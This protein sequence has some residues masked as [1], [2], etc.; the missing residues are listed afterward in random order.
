MP[1]LIL[2]V[3]VLL[4]LGAGGGIGLTQTNAQS[5]SGRVLVSG[6]ET[7]KSEA[8]V[9]STKGVNKTTAAKPT[10]SVTTQLIIDT[11]LPKVT[12]IA[13]QN[14]SSKSA[15]TR[16]EVNRYGQKGERVF[17]VYGYDER[18]VRNVI[19]KYKSFADI[20]ILTSDKVRVRSIDTNI[21]V[22][23]SYA[24]PL[25][26]LIDD[27]T[28]FYTYCFEYE[29]GMTCGT[30]RTFKTVEANYR[31]DSFKKPTLTLSAIK[32]IEAYSADVSGSYRM[33]DGENGVVFLVY[34]ENKASVDAVAKERTYRAV[35][36]NG[37]NLQ[38]VRLAARTI[39][40]GQFSYTISDIDRATQ[41]FY[42][43]CV[44]Y[45]SDDIDGM[46]CSYTSSFTTDK[47]DQSDKPTITISNAIAAVR[48]VSLSSAVRMNDFNDGHAFFVYGTKESSVQGVSAVSK[49]T[50]IRQ[51]G[52][53]L[54]LVSLDTD[55]DGSQSFSKSI[56]DLLSQTK[57]FYRSCVEY[58]EEND[59]GYA[60][61]HLSCSDVKSFTT[62][63]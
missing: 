57:Y 7:A 42:R 29:R 13:A 12:T 36:E 62:G 39:G 9:V 63:I 30:V 22:E 27:I 52:D 35:D 1:Y 18:S 10:T 54:Q 8:S 43:V 24:T 50:S 23:E 59:R 56:R 61:L 46:N 25:S 45:I 28:Y 19:S 51:S 6:G 31:S 17:V 48:I 44:E 38:K 3:L 58:A 32:N 49:F 4:V 55:V 37:E 15:T 11:R 14:V 16:A 40:T 53:S 20:P 33:N 34:G 41:H 5:E 60:T 2:G 47:R 21:A 26:A